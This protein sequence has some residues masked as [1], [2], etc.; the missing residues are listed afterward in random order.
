MIQANAASRFALAGLR[1]WLGPFILTSAAA[2]LGVWLI[3]RAYPMAEVGK[4]YLALLVGQFF[5]QIFSIFS[6]NN[7]SRALYSAS[8]GSRQALASSVLKA[9]MLLGALLLGLVAL[10]SASLDHIAPAYTS[11]IAFAGILFGIGMS[12]SIVVQSY[13]MAEGRR[14]AASWLPANAELIRVLLSAT[15]IFFGAGIVFQMFIA[16]LG[17]FAML[18][19]VLTANPN[20]VRQRMDV[21]QLQEVV[22]EGSYL[23]AAGLASMIAVRAPETV[24]VHVSGVAAFGYYSIAQQISGQLMKIFEGARTILLDWFF[25]KDTSEIQAGLVPIAAIAGASIFALG[26]ICLMFFINDYIFIGRF[27]NAVSLVVLLLAGSVIGV[28]NYTAVLLLTACGQSRYFISTAV[29]QLTVGSA[30]AFALAPSMGAHAAAVGYI[31]LQFVGFSISFIRLNKVSKPTN[32]T[33]YA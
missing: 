6:S 24:L 11:E 1:L 32:K 22:G 33:S 23:Q 15:A 16:C 30:A 17:R 21:S 20:F 5:Q 2:V 27:D 3:A 7:M 18:A 10:L 26:L 4:Y 12:S 28:G 13:L 29:A 19:I 9:T 25:R 14:M 8:G 31:A